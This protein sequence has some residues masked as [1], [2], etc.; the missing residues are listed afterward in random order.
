MSTRK[1]YHLIKREAARW[2]ATGM[3][4]KEVAAKVGIGEVALSRWVNNDPDFK[5]YLAQMC[6]LRDWQV[7]L[8]ELFTD[9]Q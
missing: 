1:K 9:P 6:D 8:P 5:H 2:L 7:I 4:Q 3:R